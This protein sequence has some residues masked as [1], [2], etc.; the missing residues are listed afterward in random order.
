M[1]SDLFKEHEWPYDT[2]GRFGLTREMLEDLP[3]CV[4]DALNQGRR[5]PVL[6]LSFRTEDGT[7]VKLQSRFALVRDDNGEAKVMF[8][9]KI[10]KSDLSLFNEAQQSQL[11][12]GKAVFSR[13]TDSNGTPQASFFQIDL[14]TGQVLSVPTPVIGNNLQIVTDRFHLSTPELSC[15]RNGDLLTLSVEDNPVTIGIDLNDEC[16]VRVVAGGE[17][18]WRRQSMREWDKYTFGINGC[19]ISDD[20]GNMRYVVED[21]Y[22]EELWN[23]QKKAGARTVAQH[24]HK[25]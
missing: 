5:S 24:Q 16:G 8:Y 22:D 3:M 18:E 1:K 14:P 9:P 19:W 7:L 23:E 17:D 6:P 20:E 2:L 21:D 15:L 10:E 25:L 13:F 12:S 11:N 4:I